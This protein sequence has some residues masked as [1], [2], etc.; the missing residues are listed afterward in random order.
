M[1]SEIGNK[2]ATTENGTPYLLYSFGIKG[3][4]D[5]PNAFF[6]SKELAMNALMQTLLDELEKNKD[7]Q[8]LVWRKFPDYTET[9][10]AG[11]DTVYYATARWCFE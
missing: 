11:G 6:I 4:C 10:L 7:K 1:K 9:H 2:R 5:L 8:T 3:D